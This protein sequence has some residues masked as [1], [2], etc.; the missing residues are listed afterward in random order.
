[1]TTLNDQY[2][3]NRYATNAAGWDLG[4]VSPPLK[5]YVDQLTDK[6]LR[7][8]MPGCGNGYE[9]AY[10]LQQGFTNITVLDIAPLLV[11]ELQKQFAH[12]P[13]IKIIAGD[14][15]THEGEY[16]LI[17]EQTFFCAINPA[18]RPAYA[19]QMH[20]LLAPGGKLVGVLF[21]REFEAAGPPFGGSAAE[22]L[23][24]FEPYFIP[25]VFAPCYNSVKP[26]AGNELFVALQSVGIG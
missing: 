9:A 21:S 24:Y 2:W 12:E 13:R 3:N 11:A 15:F 23:P 4:Q 5:A 16:D 14:F 25:L 8:L 10:L 6:N 20:Q 19:Q 22:Y 17:L 18:L 26:R 1:M 7:I